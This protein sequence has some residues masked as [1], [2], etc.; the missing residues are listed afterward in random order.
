[1]GFSSNGGAG[2]AEDP[3]VFSVE[4]ERDLLSASFAFDERLSLFGKRGGDLS[5]QLV[6][7]I[8]NFPLVDFDFS[9]RELGEKDE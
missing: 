2:E 4:K 5:F 7:E 9:E 1:E 6:T 3:G 8:M